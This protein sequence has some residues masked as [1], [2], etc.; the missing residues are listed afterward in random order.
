MVVGPTSTAQS[1]DGTGAAERLTTSPNQQ[2]PT[3]VTP[4]LTH[5][6]GDEIAPQTG[7]DVL[8]FSLGA[9][10]AAGQPLVRTSFNEVNAAIS[11][12][13]RYLAYQSN[14]TGRFEIYVRPYPKVDAGKWQVST[15]GG[16]RPVWSNGELNYLDNSNSMMAV[17]G[18]TPGNTFVAGNPVKL[19]DN[20]WATG[21]QRSFD[22]TPDGRRRRDCGRPNRQTPQAALVRSGRGSRAFEQSRR[23]PRRRSSVLRGIGIHLGARSRWDLGAEAGVPG[24][25]GHG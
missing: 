19:F 4:D 15:N 8:L 1:A 25:F 11:R 14:E 16:T 21:P 10:A 23:V 2:S 20:V 12:D 7:I 6:I 3:A 13:G 9:P 17:S 5:V 22:V 24:R 18:Q